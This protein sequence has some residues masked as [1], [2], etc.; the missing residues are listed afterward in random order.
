MLDIAPEHIVE[1]SRLTPGRML[2]VDT[3]RKKIVSDEESKEFYAT[4]HPYGEWLDSNLIHLEDLTIPNRQVEV[5]TQEERDRLYKVFGYGY[6]E[7]KSYISEAAEN[8]A[9]PTVSM[10]HDVP[11][12]S[13][14]SRII[15]R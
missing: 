14:L 11:I 6:E 4:S 9:E 7:V 1:K 15:I 5:H 12:A 3:V 13:H 8:G 10:G 2:L